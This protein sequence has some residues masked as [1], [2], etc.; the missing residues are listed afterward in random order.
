M[1]IYAVITAT[2]TEANQLLLD[3]LQELE[4]FSFS[5]SIEL[6]VDNE[7]QKSLE[8]GGGQSTVF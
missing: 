7:G 5:R 3:I 1:F 8:M 4:V 2:I 6:I